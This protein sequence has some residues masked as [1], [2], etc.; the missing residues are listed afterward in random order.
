MFKRAVTGLAAA[1]M[2]TVSAFA[3]SAEEQA[4]LSRIT[5]YWNKVKTVEGQFSQ[6]DTK[7]GQVTGTFYIKKPGK[8]RFDYDPPSPLTVVSDGYT[9]AVEDKKLETQDRYPLVE[10][11]LSIL[12]DEDINLNRPD[13]KIL[14]VKRADGAVSVH[15]QSLK[16]DAQGDIVL[17]FNEADLSLQYWVV[18]DA[19]DITVTV[20][21][22]NVKLQGEISAEKF[23]IREDR[24]DEDRGR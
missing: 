19:A 16:K 22:S 18:R 1:I 2:F 6:V 8:F 13:L 21:V 14:S 15:I 17:A 7:K 4:S 3:L 20:R 23:F 24:E 12:V 5:D 10:T 11:P 9:V